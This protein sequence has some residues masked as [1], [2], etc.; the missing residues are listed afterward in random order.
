M[1]ASETDAFVQSLVED[2]DR[3]LNVNITL[4][5]QVAPYGHT[6]S[7]APLL[8]QMWPV[9]EHQND[10]VL[11]IRLPSIQYTPLRA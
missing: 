6:L 2:F 10:V 5:C 1:D 4:S 9:R 3:D 11:Q 7:H 8:L